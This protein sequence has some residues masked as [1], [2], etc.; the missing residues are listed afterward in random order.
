MRFGHQRNSVVERNRSGRAWSAT[1]RSAWASLQGSEALAAFDR[2][3]AIDPQYVIAWYDR[4][5]A[6]QDMKQLND[7]LASCDR[8]LA[9]DPKNASARS[10]RSV[11]LREMGRDREAEEAARRAK[12]LGA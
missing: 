7:A 9:L 5:N 2:A 10:N 11:V 1:Q 12:A 8:A 6:L 4:G 3:I